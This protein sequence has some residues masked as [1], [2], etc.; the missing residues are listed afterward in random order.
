MFMPPH[1]LIPLPALLSPS[2]FSSS[3]CLSRFSVYTLPVHLIHPLHKL[4]LSLG[5][6]KIPVFALAFRVFAL[7][8]LLLLAHLNWGRGMSPVS[9]CL[10]QALVPWS[11]DQTGTFPCRSLASEETGTVWPERQRGVGNKR[12]RKKI[13]ISLCTSQIDHMYSYESAIM[14]PLRCAG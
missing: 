11:L 6:W 5:Y 2:T 3:S 10:L 12:E 4:S 1:I 14:A 7:T 8:F 9:A 13:K